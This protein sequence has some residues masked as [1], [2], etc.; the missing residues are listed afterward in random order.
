MTHFP[1]GVKAAGLPLCGA[2]SGVFPNTLEKRIA[3]AI[4]KLYKQGKIKAAYSCHD[5]RYFYSITEYHK[6]KDIFR[7]SKLLAHAGVQVTQT[8]L[9]SLGV[10]I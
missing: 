5:L 2:F 9:T 8:Y 4:A 1:L 10:E 7:L 6:D 3:C